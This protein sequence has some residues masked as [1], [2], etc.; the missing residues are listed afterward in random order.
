MNLNLDFTTPRKIS[1]FVGLSER[2]D[3]LKKKIIKSILLLLTRI[4]CLCQDSIDEAKTVV[5]NSDNINEEITDVNKEKLHNSK[6][7]I[8]TMNIIESYKK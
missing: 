2:N 5:K 8:N 3:L 4:K 7:V 6:N 1:K